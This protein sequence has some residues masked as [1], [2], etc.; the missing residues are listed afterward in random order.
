MAINF[1]ALPQAKPENLGGFELPDEGIHAAVIESAS[2]KISTAQNKYIEVVFKLQSGSKVWDK[3]MESEKPAL[4]Y[5]LG[6]FLRAC[7]IPLTGAM[8]LEDLAKV[9]VGKTV[10][11]DICHKPNTYNGETKIRAEVELF[12]GDIYYL[13]ED[14]DPTSA[15]STPQSS[16]TS[17][18]Y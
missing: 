15:P 16:E 17:G 9:I 8:E 10:H 14:I 6:R 7:R 11:V 3:I 2:I 1:D 18:T 5:K 4:Q 12:K 13:P